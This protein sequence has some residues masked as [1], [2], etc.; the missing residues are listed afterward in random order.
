MYSSKARKFSAVGVHLEAPD[1]E[2]I[3]ASHTIV[4]P[5]F[6]DTHRHIWEGIL[7][8]IG[9]DV[10]LE[11]DESYL[12]FILGTLAP[13]YRPQDVYAGNLIS[14][15]GAI[16]A[17]IT[18]LLDWSHN[19]ASPDHTDGAIS[20]LQESGLRSVF[21]YGFPWFGEWNDEQPNWFLRAANELLL[22]QGPAPDARPGAL[23]AGVRRHRD[24]QGALGSSY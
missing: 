12:A 22:V 20:A 2:A 24:V 10:P 23:R 9:A 18:T 5:G 4:M 21:A 15:Y 7:R 14:A 16:N 11:G 19:Q 3:D 6:I 8:N 1:A 13:A 17:G